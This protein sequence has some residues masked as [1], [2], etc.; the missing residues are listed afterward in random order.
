MVIF[1]STVSR[2]TPARRIRRKL[3]RVAAGFISVHSDCQRSCYDRLL[4]KFEP[5]T[6]IGAHRRLQFCPISDDLQNLQR[7]STTWTHGGFVLAVCMPNSLA[8]SRSHGSTKSGRR[9]AVLGAPFTHPHAPR[10]DLPPPQFRH[11]VRAREGVFIFPAA[12]PQ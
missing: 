11:R 8:M 6:V 9:L 3:P 10:A 12:P 4:L 2:R 5:G 1:P 7:N